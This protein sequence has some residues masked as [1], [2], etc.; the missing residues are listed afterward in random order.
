MSS[1]SKSQKNRKG[2]KL[3]GRAAPNITLAV[4]AGLGLMLTTVLLVISMTKSTLPFCA[5]G[6]GCDVVQSSRWST[7]FGISITAWGWGV[8]AVLAAA[9]V[10]VARTISRWRTAIFFATI[11]FGVSVYLNV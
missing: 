4:L 11:G 8:Y 9:A 6:S 5:S 3:S 7:L 10:L 2:T 1:K